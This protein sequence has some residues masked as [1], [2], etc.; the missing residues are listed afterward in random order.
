MITTG[1]LKAVQNFFN[2]G[3][4]L[5]CFNDTYIV[6]IPK[7]PHSESISKF[8]TIFLCNVIYKIISKVLVLRLKSFFQ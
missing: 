8:Q 4:L 3:H 1:V 6:L 5:K 7:V 2:N